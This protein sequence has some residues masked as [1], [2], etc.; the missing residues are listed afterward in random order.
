MLNIIVDGITTRSLTK[1]I[2]RGR[3]LSDC[4]EGQIGAL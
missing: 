3:Y 2:R 4:T 1:N